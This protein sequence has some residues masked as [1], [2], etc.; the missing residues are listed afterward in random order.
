M[1]PGGA[2]VPLFRT[3]KG[4]LQHWEDRGGEVGKCPPY[5][6]CQWPG[7]N[8]S[9]KRYSPCFVMKNVLGLA[10]VWVYFSSCLWNYGL[11]FLFLN[12]CQNSMFLSKIGLRYP[13]L[14][15]KALHV[16]LSHTEKTSRIKEFRNTDT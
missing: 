11:Q 10:E 8:V 5:L 1:G 7:I 15:E 6:I 3:L 13:L 9:F 14:P 4:A 12:L 16:E 2:L